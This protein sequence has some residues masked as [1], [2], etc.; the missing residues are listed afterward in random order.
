MAHEL[1]TTLQVDGRWMN[2]KT[3]FGGKSLSDT[4]VKKMFK[5]GNLKPLGGRIFKTREQAIS[6]AR[7]RSTA[8]KELQ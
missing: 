8:M 2:F 5:S 6:A 3:V 4:Q 1:S 7:R